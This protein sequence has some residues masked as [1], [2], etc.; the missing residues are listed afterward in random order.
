MFSSI[1]GHIIKQYKVGD[2][3]SFFFATPTQ[4]IDDQISFDADRN[5]N[6]RGIIRG[7][8][9]YLND[10]VNKGYIYDFITFPCYKKF[11]RLVCEGANNKYPMVLDILWIFEKRPVLT[12]CHMYLNESIITCLLWEREIILRK[13][14]IP[15]P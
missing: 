10:Y 1:F 3:D 9:K 4:P 8:N 2:I 12:R 6:I 7:S 5:K 15:A 14:I 11:R 13:K